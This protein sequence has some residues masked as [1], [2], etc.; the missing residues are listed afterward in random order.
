MK[1]GR[2]AP[3]GYKHNNSVTPAIAPAVNWYTKGRAKIPTTFPPSTI[4]SRPCQSLR[5][6]LELEPVEKAAKTRTF[7]VLLHNDRGRHPAE[8]IL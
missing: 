6:P 1:R 2:N 4:S 7:L 5:S 8:I 3:S